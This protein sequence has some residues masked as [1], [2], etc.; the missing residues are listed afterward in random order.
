MKSKLITIITMSL[1]CSLATAQTLYKDNYIGANPGPESSYTPGTGYNNSSYD[2]KD[3]VGNG[4]HYELQGTRATLSITDKELIVEIFGEY[5]DNVGSDNTNVGDLFISTQ[6]LIGLNTTPGPHGLSTE[7]DDWVGNGWDFAVDLIDSATD[8]GNITGTFTDGAKNL[9]QIDGPGGLI[10]TSN[11]VVLANVPGGNYII[12][13]G[14]EVFIQ[15]RT[16]T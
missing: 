12:R 13:N 14:Q 4:S 11:E 15:E 10:N 1:V 9:I 6:G 16:G 3:V 5:F 2:G 7:L 8:L